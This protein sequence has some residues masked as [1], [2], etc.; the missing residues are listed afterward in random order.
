M[1]AGLERIAGLETG[2]LTGRPKS[3]RERGWQGTTVPSAQQHSWEK[4]RKISAQARITFRKRSQ[5]LALAGERGEENLSF[6]PLLKTAFFSLLS[7]DSE[8]FALALDL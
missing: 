2:S 3:A 5:A 4:T 6:F 1:K 7:S 8:T